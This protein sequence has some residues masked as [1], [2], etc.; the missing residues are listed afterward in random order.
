VTAEAAAQCGIQ[1][2]VM[3]EK[4]TVAALVGAIVKYV[5]SVREPSLESRA[6]I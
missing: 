6:T 1:T 3:P 2:A 4:Y 5:D